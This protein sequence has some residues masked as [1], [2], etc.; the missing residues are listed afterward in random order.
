M[1]DINDLVARLRACPSIAE[2]MENLDLPEIH[3]LLDHIEA[4]AAEIERLRR[5]AGDGWKNVAENSQ[6]IA[7]KAA[8][9]TYLLRRENVRLVTENANLREKSGE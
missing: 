8:S 3:A 6:A 7:E 5:E 4:Q 9:E 2:A 1:T